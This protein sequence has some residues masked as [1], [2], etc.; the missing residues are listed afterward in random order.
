MR[1]AA[2]GSQAASKGS[3]RG[4]GDAEFTRTAVA[5]LTITEVFALGLLYQLCA[6]L[7]VFGTVTVATRENWKRS[8]RE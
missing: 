7:P 1:E 8:L 4:S 2:G 5:C 6:E 3:V